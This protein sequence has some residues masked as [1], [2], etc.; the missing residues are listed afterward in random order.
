M[1]LQ[2]SNGSASGTQASEQ[3][4][5]SIRLVVIATQG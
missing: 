2:K 5:L 1:V 4:L 3:I